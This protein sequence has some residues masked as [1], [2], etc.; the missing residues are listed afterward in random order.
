ML[1]N[2]YTISAFPDFLI[3]MLS[4]YGV[5]SFILYFVLRQVHS[6]FQIQFSTECD[7]LLLLSIYSILF[8]R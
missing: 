1:E 3:R 8:F 5:G 4:L 2:C 7:L 6:L